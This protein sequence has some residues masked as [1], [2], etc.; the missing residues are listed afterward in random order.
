MA[1]ALST[2]ASLTLIIAW[3]VIVDGVVQ[4]VWC[5]FHRN[6]NLRGWGLVLV[7]GAVSMILGLSVLSSLSESS[8]YLVGI[9]LGVNFLTLGNG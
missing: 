5:C 6:N 9:L 7:S 8:L 2:L 4:V 1:K 3:V